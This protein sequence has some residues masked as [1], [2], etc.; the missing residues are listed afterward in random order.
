MAEHPIGVEVVTPERALF[1]GPAAA[2]VASTSE[3]DLTVMA[4]HAELI[5]DVVAGIV[6]IEEIDGSIEDVIVHGGFI[7][8]HSG[9]GAAADLLEDVPDTERTTRVTVLAG[10]AEILS[11]V[12]LAHV[13]TDLAEAE[14]RMEQLRAAVQG[15]TD[16]D[17]VREAEF[18]LSQAQAHLSR[19]QLRK[20]AIQKRS[21]N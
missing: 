10:Q 18:E 13:E 9:I 16:D 11:E 17:G 20:I 15:K 7:Q 3:G 2:L 6:K 5:G 8:I 4:G 19:A 14:L 21:S 1:S 12:D